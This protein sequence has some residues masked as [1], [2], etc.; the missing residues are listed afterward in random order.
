MAMSSCLQKVTTTFVW[1][2]EIDEYPDEHSSK[3]QAASV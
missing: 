1:D 3:E 2:S